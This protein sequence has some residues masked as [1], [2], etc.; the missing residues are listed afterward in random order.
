[1]PKGLS[2]SGQGLNKKLLFKADIVKK[3]GRVDDGT[4]P[5]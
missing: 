4:P 5:E 1:M 2:A 3:Y